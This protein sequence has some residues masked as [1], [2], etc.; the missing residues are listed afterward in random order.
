[1][2][3]FALVLTS[4]VGTLASNLKKTTATS[5]IEVKLSNGSSV[6]GVQL[7]P[8]KRDFSTLSLIGLVVG[9]SSLKDAQE[10]F[11]G[12]TLFHDGPKD[13]GSSVLCYQG[14]DQSMVSFESIGQSAL[15]K[16]I[17]TLLAVSGPKVGYRYKKQ[18]SP[19][20]SMRASLTG[21]SQIRLGL[22]LA[23]VKRRIGK[24][25]QESENLLLYAYRDQKALTN[26]P[27]VLE[28]HFSNGKL[29]QYIYS[30]T[31]NDESPPSAR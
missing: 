29:S 6:S 1:M 10:K 12:G 16:G 22:S 2:I 9:E 27:T 19:A 28:Y 18:C 17:I 13:S 20:D 24:P 15:Q 14:P 23:E 11:K 25:S 8:K 4:S 5:G 26:V 21:G 7:I 30:S 31:F 3:T